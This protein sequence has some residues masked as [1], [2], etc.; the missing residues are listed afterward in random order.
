MKEKPPVVVI[1]G[2]V[3]HGKTTL[4]DYIR[5]T[6][7]AEKEAGG[8]TQKVG[9]YEIEFQNKKITFIDTPGHEAFSKLRERGAKIADLG[10]LLIAADDGVMPQTLESLEY[11]KAYQ[12]PFVVAINKM[13]KANADPEK[14]LSELANAGCLVE[15]W[16]GDIPYI[17]LSAKTG[18]GIE[19]LLSLILLL[20]EMHG[21]QYDPNKPGEGVILEVSK[22]SKRGIL[23]GAIVTNG[24]VSAE[25]YI[26]TASSYAKIKIFEDQFGNR[27]QV[28]Y[29]SMPILVG[30]FA[31]L[32]FVGETFQVGTKEDIEIIKRNL[33]EK[34]F[35]FRQ[36][37]LTTD[38]AT[39]DF[40]F[41]I[42]ADHIGSLEA[43]EGLLKNLSEKYQKKIKVVKGDIGSPT[44]DDIKLAKQTNSIL[45]FFNVKISN[46]ILR[47]LQ[48][49]NLLWISHNVVYHLVEDLEK[50]LSGEELG[51]EIKGRLEVLE[52]FSKTASRQTIG[53]RVLEGSFAV[54]YRVKIMRNDFLVGR[55]KIVSLKKEKVS[56]DSVVEGELCGMMIE[57]KSDI[58][59]GDFIERV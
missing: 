57:T 19:D 7:V 35:T 25:D 44:D 3:D 10:I 53:G 58:S 42:K 12:I 22:D 34:E 31:E 43:I 18:D 55:G 24:K 29:P 52:T 26:I 30:P 28:A 5:K 17:K 2:H 1:L 21:L 47:D 8:I 6:N 41:I 49:F 4:L 59:V 9:A 39:G 23:A 11:L 51:R 48:D 14:V 20:A 40:N 38:E 36:K 37:I 46:K 32:P 50:I 16:G 33:K 56:V 27:L 54:N 13:D 15:G 45:V